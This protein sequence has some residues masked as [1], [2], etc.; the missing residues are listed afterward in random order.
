MMLE[1]HV[2]AK[3]LGTHGA[4]ATA[5]D[6]RIALDTDI[7]GRRD[8]FNPAELLLA[9][10]SACMI[11]GA[12][13]VAPMLDFEL[14]GLEIELHGTRQDSPPKMVSITYEITVDSDETDQRLALLHKNIRKYGTI[15]NTLDSALSLSG[16]IRRKN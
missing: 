16:T 3:R 15:S 11:K 4:E 2:S 13:R 9:A 1:Y 12:E 5:K 6:A 8:A 7:A 14:R 10:L